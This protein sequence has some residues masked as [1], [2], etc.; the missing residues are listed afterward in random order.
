MI[1]D[2][3]RR[4]DVRGAARILFKTAEPTPQ[5]VDAVRRE[6]ARGSL[7]G[8]RDGR[9]TTAQAVAD[10]LAARTY[11]RRDPGRGRSA[12][13]PGFAPVAAGPAAG[14]TRPRVVRSNDRL[15]SLYQDLLRDYVLAVCRRQQRHRRSKFFERA[16]VAGQVACLL[17]ILGGFAI[18]LHVS[19]TLRQ[20]PEQEAVERWI[21]ENSG[22]YHVI[23]WYPTEPAR[24]GGGALVRVEYQY[25]SPSRKG[26]I[27]DRVFE[28]RG[29]QVTM[30]DDS[31]P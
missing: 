10:F 9:W 15:V 5:Q 8:S 24:D 29:D 16:V 17:L 25:F 7:A 28:V 20:P 23:R 1:G 4:L 27:T 6:L 30:A 3:E 13:S 22:D 21:A 26:I 11:E 19:R 31:E 14:A 18:G 2:D 12:D